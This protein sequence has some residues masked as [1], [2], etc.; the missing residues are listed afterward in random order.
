MAATRPLCVGFSSATRVAR[1]QLGNLEV[2]FYDEATKKMRVF[3]LSEETLRLVDLCL[4][5]WR[6]E[7]HEAQLLTMNGGQLSA[8]LVEAARAGGLRDVTLLIR[9]GADVNFAVHNYSTALM[10]S[11]LGGHLAIV[12]TLLDAGAVGLGKPLS[13]AALGK[14]INVMA[15]LLDRGA[16]IHYDGD[17]ALRTAAN[18]GGLDGGSDGLA[19]VQFLLDRGANIHA[20]ND[21]ALCQDRYGRYSL[22]MTRLLLDRG[23]NI[24]AQNDKVLRDV[25]KAG[26]LELT[27]FLL[28]RGAN[29]HALRDGVLQTVASNGTAEMMRLLLD[30]G[31]DADI[32]TQRDEPLFLAA[33]RGRQEMVR[34]LLERGAQVYDS[35]TRRSMTS[36]IIAAAQ[37]NGHQEV[38]QLLKEHGARQRAA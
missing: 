10:V 36:R 27:R 13:Y 19:M 7:E 35:G 11:S 31:A 5:R 2:S 4:E 32:H 12:T 6:R 26:H 25:V 14:K 17:D 8:T 23:A 1:F 20:R 33:R 24:H 29:V 16:D 30:R 3:V 38:A 34:L 28:D 22:E 15:L 18:F 9:L 37:A 21:A